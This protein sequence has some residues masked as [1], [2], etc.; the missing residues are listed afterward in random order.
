MELHSIVQPHGGAARLRRET[1]STSVLGRTA[2]ACLFLN[3]AFWAAIIYSLLSPQAVLSAQAIQ[4]ALSVVAF[5]IILPLFWSM[6]LPS[7]PAGRL[8]QKQTWHLPGQVAITM[9]AL[10][11]TYVAGTLMRIWWNSQSAVAEAGLAT[12]FTMVS[13]IVG[14]LVPAIAWCVVTPEQW[15]AQLE[16]VR[17]VRRIEH[18]M[19]LEEAAMRASYARAVSLLNADLI[20]LSIEQKQ[21]LAGIL[22]GFA[23]VQQQAIGSI[24]ASWKDMY[25]VEQA[26]NSIPDDELMQQYRNV[27]AALTDSADMF[28]QSANYAQ[29]I[30]APGATAPTA[31]H[32]DARS[33]A[34]PSAP[35]ATVR[36]SS[37]PLVAPSA[38]V[39]HVQPYDAAQRA[40]SGAW[41]RSELEKAL[42]VSKTQAS[43]YIRDWIAAGLV[44]T[45]SNPR[46]HYEWTVQP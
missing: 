43:T 15:A 20:N 45:L 12:T 17:A 10:F 19:A 6:L 1:T 42:S 46:D 27:A 22:G 28:A 30:A 35:N 39:P 29:Q 31:A 7:S 38:T 24:A 41:K 26:V 25:G 8:L 33:V 2:F 37:E 16:Q 18:A 40:L 13:L 21:E 36:P 11:L 3:G 32:P 23:R 34:A 14:V 44:I 9:A 5:A 4:I